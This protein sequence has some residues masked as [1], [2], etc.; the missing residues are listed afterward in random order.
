LG[1]A[2]SRRLVQAMG[3]ELHLSSQAG[4]GSV[5]SFDVELPVHEAP[6][7]PLE[8]A[9]AQHLLLVEPHEASSTALQ[10]L[11]GTLGLHVT[12]VARGDEARTAL[13]ANPGIRLAWLAAQLPDEDG[14]H[15]A[16]ALQAL[17][18]ERAQPL[19]W[20]LTGSALQREP[21]AAQL[22]QSDG[23]AGFVLKPVCASL[24]REALNADP[25]RV[26]EIA[27]SERPLTGLHLLVAEDNPNNQQVAKELLEHEGA[28]I[29]L[30][31]DGEQALALLRQQR[32]QPLRH[33]AFDAV[34]MDMQMPVMDGL[35][36]ARAIRTELGLTAAQLPIIAMTAN[37]MPADREACLAAGMN[38]HV[39]KPFELEA[40]VAVLLRLLPDRASAATALAPVQ[41]DSAALPAPKPA[42]ETTP[43]TTPKPK[44][45]LPSLRVPLEQQRRAAQQGLDLQAGMDRF[46]GRT[47]LFLRT[48]RS[49]AQQAAE[50]PARLRTAM[51]AEP[52]DCNAAQQQLHSFKG[53]AAT[54]ASGWPS[55][56]VPGRSVPAPARRWRRP[57]STASRPSCPKGW[58]C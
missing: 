6:E 33:Q 12:A 53:L 48:A 19:R 44:R 37:A 46:L 42:A 51:S 17:Q 2:L 24:A 1:L 7:P 28:Q 3:G 10:S 13:Q 52:P 35:S 25:T 40:L 57:G 55:G 36:A 5:F 43:E 32:L 45:S 9:A 50:L 47:E 16:Q 18:R 27:S 11:L 56:G 29:T 38:E 41:P 31:D 8:V 23:P 15:C 22:A 39:G 14:W 30:A 26:A 21:L 54:L 58:R 34:L 4:Q 20:W 49:F